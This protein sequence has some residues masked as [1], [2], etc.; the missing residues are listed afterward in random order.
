MRIRL[1]IALSALA[2]AACDQQQPAANTTNQPTIKVRSPE[3]DQLHTLDAINLAI[4]LKRAI[5][6]AGFTCRQVTD[7]GFIGEYENLDMWMARCSEGREWA[8]FAGPDG[9]AQVRDCKDVAGTEVPQCA[10][11]RRP[12][13]TFDAGQ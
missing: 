13:G 6:D 2:L 9:S 3:Q 12:R 10:I 8:V 5:Y 4:A 1:T 7:A 11:K